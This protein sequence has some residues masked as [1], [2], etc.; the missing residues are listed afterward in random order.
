MEVVTLVLIMLLLVVVSGFAVRILPFA[1]PLPLVQIALGAVIAVFTD[2]RISLNPEIFFLLFLPPLLFLDGW[3]IP[4]NGLLRD[5]GTIIELALGLVIFTVLGMGMLIHWM[6]PSMPWAIC[7]AL[8]AVLS[9]TDPVAVSAIAS[10]TPIPRRIMHILE[11]ESLL[12]D[13]S[14]LVCLRFATAAA[15]TG[16]FSL[17]SAIGTFIWLVA[18]GIGAGVAVTLG[19]S[20]V[21]GW[22]AR[23]Y[24][25]G[26]GNQILISLLIPFGAYLA[27]EHIHASGILAAVAAGVTMSY[28]ESTGQ[29][30]ASTRV[31]RSAVWDAMAFAANGI[32]FVLLGQQMPALTESAAHVVQ[33][34]GHLNPG[35]LAIYVVALML[36]LAALRFA[37]VWVSLHLTIL[38]AG[39]KRDDLGLR[40]RA[41]IVAVIS[42]AGVRGAITLAGILTLPVV[43]ADGTPLP[44]RD[45]AIFLAAW[46]IIASL[47]TAS[48]VLPR[49]AQG[50][51]VPEEPAHEIEE[52]AA[53]ALAAQAAIN[54]VETAMH[55]ARL[56]GAAN[57]ERTTQYAEA[58]AR[59]IRFYRYRLDGAAAAQGTDKATVRRAEA[60]ERDLRLKALKAERDEIFRLGRAREIEDD[61]MR[62]LVREVDLMESRY[63]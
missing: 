43:M 59:L 51:R 53:R 31:G 58:G 55:E 3:R 45:L 12:N 28:V 30:L 38:R 22:V 8:A 1:V 11:G 54:V 47:V 2:V 42:V 48:I 50:L 41:R 9:P 14:G 5:K 16:V 29:V 24:G 6:I 34:T 36:A 19:A 44:A 60:A 39:A 10:R 27:A 35:W 18:A 46:V 23:R 63:T 4:K 62:K 15:L 56:T 37:W 49:L 20:A 33:E 52:D 61:M 57:I 25:E 7:F 21:K 32:I 40:M 26:T 17:T 13:A